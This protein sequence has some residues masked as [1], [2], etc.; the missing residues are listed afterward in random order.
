[1]AKKTATKG[2][3]WSEAEAAYTR[4]FGGKDKYDKRGETFESLLHEAD[5]CLG[6]TIPGGK[7]GEAHA[8]K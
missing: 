1:M 7:E 2:Y 3:N 5:I 4:V 6:E 8:G